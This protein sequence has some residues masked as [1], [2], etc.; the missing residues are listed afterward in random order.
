MLNFMILVKIFKKKSFFYLK[1]VIGVV[2][3]VALFGLLG[4]VS[5]AS[6]EIS[7]GSVKALYHFN[8]DF[9]DSS[10][11]GHNGTAQGNAIATGTTVKLGDYSSQYDGTGDYVTVDLSSHFIGTGDFAIGFWFRAS[12]F[13]NYNAFVGSRGS[14]PDD[15]TKFTISTDV[16]K[17]LVFYVGS[18]GYLIHTNNAFVNTNQW[19]YVVFTRTGTTLRGYVDNVLIETNASVSQDLSVANIS[20]GANTVGGEAFTGFIDEFV[21]LKGRVLSV[22]ERTALYNSGVGQEVCVTAGCADVGGGG[23]ATSTADDIVAVSVYLMV[24][25]I[26]FSL[27]LILSIWI[28]TRFF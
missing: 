18:T 22:D 20:I 15:D 4:N 8:G 13:S 19:Y 23:T 24:G 3:G 16:N 11:N 28:W 26:V 21:F 12:S 10:G 9:V 7:D 27:S 2:F 17:A 5:F 14:A 6:Y 1:M 25:V